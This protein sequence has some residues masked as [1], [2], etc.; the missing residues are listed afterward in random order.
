M[1]CTKVKITEFVWLT[2][3]EYDK[4]RMEGGS[5]IKKSSDDKSESIEHFQS[6]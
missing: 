2:K 4:A 3:E 5:C 6:V 1:N